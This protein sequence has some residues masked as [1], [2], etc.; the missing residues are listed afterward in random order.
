M[1]TD[2]DGNFTDRLY[3]YVARGIYLDHLKIWMDVYPVKQFLILKIFIQKKLV[4]MNY[5]LVTQ[6]KNTNTVTVLYDATKKITINIAKN[7][8]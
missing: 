7:K 3:Q 1:I 6:E 5:V 8:K 4:E 2:Y